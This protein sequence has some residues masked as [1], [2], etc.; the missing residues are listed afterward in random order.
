PSP[1]PTPFRSHEDV[2]A[3]QLDAAAE[4]ACHRAPPGY[5]V[6]AQAV[7]DGD[8]RVAVEQ[9]LVPVDHLLAREHEVLSTQPVAAA[10]FGELTRRHVEGQEDV[11][12]RPAAGLRPHM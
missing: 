8:D 4:L 12:A 7:L 2:V 11:P 1:S 10:G 5:V 6:L 9:L 3:D